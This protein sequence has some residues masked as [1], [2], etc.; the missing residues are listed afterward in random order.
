M[1]NDIEQEIWDTLHRHLRSV[2]DRDVATYQATTSEELS[3]Y[4]W[5]ISP[6]RMDGLPFHLY[7]I[8]LFMFLPSYYL[9]FVKSCCRNQAPLFS[10]PCMLIRFGCC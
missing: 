8:R 10:F 3:L 9:P 1:S 6:H 2:Y 4:E 7:I 5:F